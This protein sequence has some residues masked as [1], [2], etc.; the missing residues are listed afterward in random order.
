MP[1]GPPAALARR[2]CSSYWLRLIFLVVFAFTTLVSAGSDPRSPLLGDC[3]PSQ[4]SYHVL[5]TRATSSSPSSSSYNNT[6][7][8]YAFDSSL[9]TN[10]TEESC[11]AFFNNFLDD[12]NFIQC[13]PFSF[14]LQ[15]SES[16]FQIVRQGAFKL[17]SAMDMI[18]AVN[19]TQCSTLMNDYA[20]QLTASS[21]CA[22]DY[23][24]ENPLVRQAYNAF[25]SYSMLYSSGCLQSTSGSYCYVDSVTN[26]TNP[27]DSYLYY[28]PLDVSL[29]GGTRAGCS[30]CSQDIMSIFLNFAGNSSLSISRTYVPAAQQ[31]NVYCGPNFAST[32][33]PVDRVSTTSSVSFAAATGHA[34][35]AAVIAGGATT[36]AYLFQLI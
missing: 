2:A 35:D 6:I 3:S 28:L 27:G 25:T 21:N 22:T 18:C 1:F 5:K 26:S 9:G 24:L 8:P 29:P 7:V 20:S 32:A 36:F 10:F 31:I 19:A 23:Q 13:Y 4:R 34:R 16:F 12:E 11:P 30:S 15:N 33:V 14:F 17:S